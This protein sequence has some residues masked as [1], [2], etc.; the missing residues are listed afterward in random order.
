MEMAFNLAPERLTYIDWPLF[1]ENPFVFYFSPGSTV[2]EALGL[3]D[4]YKTILGF[5]CNQF[6]P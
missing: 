2:I 6:S 4:I 3:W 1:M 5:Q